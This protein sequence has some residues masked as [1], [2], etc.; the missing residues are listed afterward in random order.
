MSEQDQGGQPQ[1]TETGPTA[2]SAI[3]ATPAAPLSPTPARAAQAASDPGPATAE[4]SLEPTV[5][6]V[7]PTAP[8]QGV[9]PAKRPSRAR[10]AVAGLIALLVVVLA[11]AGLYA[12]VGASNSSVV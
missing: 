2:E 10:W 12:L 1:P 8:V 9:P 4:A 7:T 11:G 6:S 5:S 3:P